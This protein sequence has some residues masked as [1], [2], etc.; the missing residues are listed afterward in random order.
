MPAAADSKARELSSTQHGII[1]AAVGSMEQAL[2]RPTVYWKAELQQNR[3]ELK[4]AVNPRY[5]YRGLPVAVASIAPI[6]GIQFAATH[7]SMKG[8]QVIRG[9]TSA[10]QESS[11]SDRDAI[12]CGVFAGAT[13]AI[14]QSP[15]QMIEINQQRQGGNVI[16]MARRILASHGIIGL[17]RGVSMTACREGIFCASY[18]GISPFVKK[19]LQ[20][21]RPDLSDT[22]ALAASSIFA[23]CLG[24]SLSHPADTIKTRLQGSVFDANRV[25]GPLEALRE[26]RAQ[27]GYIA[28]C[29]R[30]IV[31]RA[32]RI[33][34][35]TFIY[36][37]LST[38]IG[39][40]VHEFNSG[41][42]NAIV[43]LQGLKVFSMHG[44][45]LTQ[46]S[47]QLAV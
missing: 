17:Y 13:S 18:M 31:P 36:S 35:C 24:A 45:V 38:A 19:R 47:Q 33:S 25:S 20:E 5:C 32:F 27:K 4:K 42:V 29:Y 6:T 9:A 28:E 40:L 43:Q 30:G 1:G 16:T 7:L 41:G 23:G 46:Q 14:V 2:M 3:L 44:P 22:A 11:T 26:M 21:E 12:L 34:C 15:F 10:L 8:L 39:D 37:S